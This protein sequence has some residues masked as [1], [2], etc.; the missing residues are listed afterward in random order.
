MIALGLAV[1]TAC[2][3][4][5]ELPPPPPAI[6]PAPTVAP[7]P[8]AAIGVLVAEQ[9]ADI[10]PPFAGVLLRV[11]VR[12]GD[13]VA[14]GQVVAEM[15]PRPLEEELR[16]AEAARGV[17]EAMR[18]QAMVDI[19]DA[20]RRLTVETAAVVAGVSPSTSA[21]EARLAVKRMQAAA[22]RAL[23]SL[24]QESARLT[25]ARS[26]LRDSK[27]TA[28]FAGRVAIRYLDA[29]AML[30]PGRAVI[31]LVGGSV[32]LRFAVPPEQV[33]RVQPGVVVRAEVENV[34][35][36]IAAVVRQVSPSLDLSSGL[37][38]I[39]AELPSSSQRDPGLRP[40]L[41]ATVHVP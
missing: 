30:A 21:D 20:E 35:T 5:P 39:E 36:P 38:F 14:I 29:G 27:L 34:A 17:A 18:R 15:D 26:H 22:A 31:R 7:D 25:S 1:L 24:A 10:A 23:A 2:R 33:A 8:G 12:P 40:G 41:A 32:R 9:I 28:P 6:L 3:S 11:V 4:H 37:L 13:L 19:E 16:V